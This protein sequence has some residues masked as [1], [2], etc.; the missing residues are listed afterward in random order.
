MPRWP[1]GAKGKSNLFSRAAIPQANNEIDYRLEMEERARG[2][3][4]DSSIMNQINALMARPLLEEREP[5]DLE[6]AKFQDLVAAE[7]SD[8]HG[9]PQDPE[10][11]WVS[12][13][14]ARLLKYGT[15]PKDAADRLDALGPSC[16]DIRTMCKQGAALRAKQQICAHGVDLSKCEDG[17]VDPGPDGNSFVLFKADPGLEKG[18]KPVGS[19]ELLNRMDYACAIRAELDKPVKERQFDPDKVFDP[20]T[21][22]GRAYFNRRFEEIASRKGMKW[23]SG[24]YAAIAGNSAVPEEPLK[25]PPSSKANGKAKAK[26][27]APNARLVSLDAP[28]TQWLQFLQSDPDVQKMLRKN[29]EREERERQVGA[30]EE[31]AS[32]AAIADAVVV[33]QWRAVRVGMDAE[34][35][36]IMAAGAQKEAAVE[37]V[38]H[39]QCTV[40]ATKEE[41]EMTE[42]EALALK[43]WAN[44]IVKASAY[45]RRS[46]VPVT[47]TK[48]VRM[49]RADGDKSDYLSL[50]GARRTSVGEGGA[51]EFRISFTY[52]N[53]ENTIVDIVMPNEMVNPQFEEEMEKEANT[54]A[55]VPIEFQR[56]PDGKNSTSVSCENALAF[57]FKTLGS[58]ATLGEYGTAEARK[59]LTVMNNVGD[60]FITNEVAAANWAKK[61]YVD[62]DGC[63]RV[64]DSLIGKEG[65]VFPTHEQAAELERTAFELQLEPLEY[66]RLLRA[67]KKTPL[68]QLLL[69]VVHL[70]S[71]MSNCHKIDTSESVLEAL[72]FVNDLLYE[73]QSLLCELTELEEEVARVPGML[74][75]VGKDDRDGMITMMRNAMESSPPGPGKERWRDALHAANRMSTEDIRSAINDG[76]ATSE[77]VPNP[78]SSKSVVAF[79]VYKWL[80]DGLANVVSQIGIG[81]GQHSTDAALEGVAWLKQFGCQGSYRLPV[82]QMETLTMPD[83]STLA[84][85][86]ADALRTQVFKNL[87]LIILAVHA[88][89]LSRCYEKESTRVICEEKYSMASLAWEGIDPSVMTHDQRI[90]LLHEIMWVIVEQEKTAAMLRTRKNCLNIPEG[91]E[92]GPLYHN[93]NALRF[94]YSGLVEI[95]HTLPVT[96]LIIN[97]VKADNVEALKGAIEFT[98]GKMADLTEDT[99]WANV[100]VVQPWLY[101]CPTGFMCHT[102]KAILAAHTE[103]IATNPVYETRD[104]KSIGE[105]ACQHGALEIVK[106]FFE[107]FRKMASVEMK[108]SGLGE[109][110]PRHYAIYT[111]MVLECFRQAEN[112]IVFEG[113]L[114]NLNSPE[115][116]MT[117]ADWCSKKATYVL[118]SRPYLATMVHAVLQR[119]FDYRNLYVTVS[120]AHAKL[121]ESMFGDVAYESSVLR[122]DTPFAPMHALL[123]TMFPQSLYTDG[124]WEIAVGTF[125]MEILT[126]CKA[127]SPFYALKGTKAA[128]FV[129]WFL[130][131]WLNKNACGLATSHVNKVLDFT[132]DEYVVA[133][134]GYT[135]LVRSC[136]EAACRHYG[137]CFESMVLD[138]LCYSTVSYTHLTLP[139][140]D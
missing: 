68:K 34:N 26:V 5:T 88:H 136:V 127:T 138:V 116:L 46:D 25:P 14:R 133:T 7:C 6:Y 12:I 39:D 89:P 130:Y 77:A 65:Q 3:K 15:G 75:N 44:A 8:E 31:G 13:A 104:T 74:D 134:V 76:M 58:Y 87:N 93:K 23:D 22:E 140:T 107:E 106:W 94:I 91:F 30:S 126:F 57:I 81:P 18:G 132:P 124:E 114:D 128:A 113:I 50:N 24:S 73:M 101:I 48:L 84:A 29:K 117:K 120:E 121:V 41:A 111:G 66:K 129:D 125:I 55:A 97:A 105:L 79:H 38:A 78:L 123:K 47:S 63:F 64:P 95:K 100:F 137:L 122:D 37:A 99:D 139:T 131:G 56:T 52:S 2:R 53:D 108:Q 72:C 36:G 92:N 67:M 71:D 102:D 9:V 98:S 62:E 42:E 85:H 17:T 16:L 19:M 90:W 118:D 119:I 40:A 70:T 109:L 69:W 51:H 27:D 1:P 4:T 135:V 115:R 86:S 110:H 33:R 32:D 43:A 10:A 61:M 49:K 112:G 60:S 83:D 28:T 20:F 59:L 82:V 21:K 103:M 11:E 35:A 54:K 45:I 96:H 80:V